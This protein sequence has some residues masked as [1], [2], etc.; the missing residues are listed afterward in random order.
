MG[1]DH[2]G[3]FAEHSSDLQELKSVVHQ[4]LTEKAD[5]QMVVA[6]IHTV[7]PC[8]YFNGYMNV[9]QQKMKYGHGKKVINHLNIK[10]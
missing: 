10:N 3:T 8:R 2:R 4:R 6:V 7:T 9:C 5:I 1:I